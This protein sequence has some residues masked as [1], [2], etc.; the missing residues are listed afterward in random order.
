MKLEF[1]GL[2]LVGL[3]CKSC[4]KGCCHIVYAYRLWIR[5]RDIVNLWKR[6][7]RYNQ[8]LQNVEKKNYSQ[9]LQNVKKNNEIYNQCLQNV[10]KKNYS[11]YIQNVEKNNKI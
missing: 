10:E 8:C 9:C 4:T 1:D 7:M 5:L 3:L 11:Q 2:V 6:I